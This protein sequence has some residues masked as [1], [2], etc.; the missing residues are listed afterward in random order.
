MNNR[1][2]NDNIICFPAHYIEGRTIQPIEVIESFGFCHH[3]AC[4]VKYLSRAGRKTSFINDLRKSEWYLKREVE[5]RQHYTRSCPSDLRIEPPYT[6]QEVIEDWD[7]SAYLSTALSY[8]L[9]AQLASCS[10]EP[11][12]HQNLDIHVSSL[13][14]ALGYLQLEIFEYEKRIT[15]EI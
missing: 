10:K 12:N 1:I 13:K 7:L 8:I 2:Y 5:R 9:S 6:I 14:R 3:L 11:S 4:V 15:D